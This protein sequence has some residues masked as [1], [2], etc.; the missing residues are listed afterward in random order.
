MRLVPIPPYLV[1][2]LC[3][4]KT[5]FPPAPDGRLFYLD[6]HAPVSGPVYRKVWKR[7]RAAALTSEE[8]A[9]KLA[10]RV[11]DLRH[12]NASLLLDD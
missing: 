8:H 7:A 10:Q 6:D 3:N 9:S 4:H 1:R 2:V 12:G 5:A 11:Y